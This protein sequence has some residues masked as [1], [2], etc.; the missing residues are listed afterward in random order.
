M[1][2][3]WFYVA[4]Q[5]FYC[6]KTTYWKV[7]S[8]WK[9]FRSICITSVTIWQFGDGAFYVVKRKR[10]IAFVLRTSR[11]LFCWENVTTVAELDFLTSRSTQK[12][13]YIAIEPS[14]KSLLKCRVKWRSLFVVKGFSSQF[15]V[16]FFTNVMKHCKNFGNDRVE[17]RCQFC[18]SQRLP[19]FW[20]ELS[21][22]LGFRHTLDF[23]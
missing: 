12:R 22:W 2:T 7:C 8:H 13:I 5:R 10:V 23:P 21:Q 3:W 4:T 17:W 15:T 1:T 11:L 9:F 6:R 16:C 19:L 20:Q 14:R 18:I